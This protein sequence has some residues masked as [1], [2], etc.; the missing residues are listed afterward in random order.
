MCAPPPPPPGTV[1]LPTEDVI[2]AT[3]EREFLTKHRQNAVCAACHS[4][5][6]PIGLALENYDAIGAW[7]TRIAAR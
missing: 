4:T 2:T 6:D 1:N 3:T 7:P 5:M